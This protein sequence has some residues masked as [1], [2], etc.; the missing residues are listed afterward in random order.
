MRLP[1]LLM[2][3]GGKGR[4]AWRSRC[5]RSLAF[6][7]VPVCSLAKQQEEIFQPGRSGSVLL[8]R[9]SP[10]LYLVQRVRDR[11]TG[12]ASRRTA[13]GA[14]RSASPR[15]STRCPASGRRADARAAQ[16]LR[17]A[18]RHP[19]RPASKSSSPSLE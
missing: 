3:D 16:P 18:R 9:R 10:A 4:W 19:A 14:T 12:S 1:D 5:C 7:V 11:P 17:L 6:D 8:P 15:C 2:I 13:R